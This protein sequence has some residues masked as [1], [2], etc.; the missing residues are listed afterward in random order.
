MIDTK[1]ACQCGNR[2]KFGMDLVEGRAPEGLLCPTCG[3]PATPACNSL[4]DFLSG[5]E[6]PPIGNGSRALKEIRVVCDCGARYKFDLELAEKEM[7][8]P[9][10]CP[11]CQVDLAPKANEEIRLFVSRQALPA[12]TPP[13]SEPAPAAA[14]PPAPT[15]PAAAAVV[16]A[17][18]SPAAAPQPSAAVLPPPA[19]AP[20]APVPAPAPAP[21]SSGVA[22]TPIEDPF[23]PAPATK[24]GPNLKP[25]EVPRPNRPAPGSKPAGAS[26]VAPG[27]KPT[28]SPSAKPD[29]AKAAAAAK[30][31]AKPDAKPAAKPAKSH[32]VDFNLG[33]AGAF[34]GAVLGAIIWFILLKTTPTSAAWMAMVVGVLAGVGARFLGRGPAPELA[35]VACIIAAVAIGAMAWMAMLRHSDRDAEKS[36]EQTYQA[37]VASAEKAAKA[38]DAELR[39]FIMQTSP[40]ASLEGRTVSDAELGAFKA[41]ELP[42]LKERASKSPASRAAFMSERIRLY[43]G[44]Q[45]W[46][47]VWENAI[48]IFGLLMLLA[49][50]IAPVKI[51]G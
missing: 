2:F 40:T 38:N 21:G 39:L 44:S 7:P 8:A 25:L 27:A 30:P 5:K 4:V 3:A 15:A 16:P 37:A 46:A 12:V 10:I 26:T 41:K 51:A 22:A 28:S 23:G 49:G 47:D 19:A 6:P 50:M 9:V 14:A 11:G 36:G 34:G 1:I 32:G 42:K 17:A 33:M 29:P 31:G 24:G 35:K 43:R 20:A 18:E 13:K 48:G 45:D